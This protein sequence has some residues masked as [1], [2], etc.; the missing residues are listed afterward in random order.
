MNNLD[1][2]MSSQGFLEKGD[3]RVRVREADVATA[4]GEEERER[5][6][7]RG[8]KVVAKYPSGLGDEGRSH[9]PKNAGGLQKLKKVI[10]GILPSGLQK[11]CSTATP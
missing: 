9:K 11:E 4:D 1:S 5:E 3:R 8:E 7:G 2:S 6:G 10:K